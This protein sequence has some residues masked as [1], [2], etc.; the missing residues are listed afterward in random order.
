MEIWL[1]DIDSVNNQMQLSNKGCKHRMCGIAGYLESKYS[2]D[3]VLLKKM[4]DAL[5]HR[6]PDTC[7]VWFDNENRVGLTHRRLSIV[8]LS[9]AGHQPMQS[10]NERFVLTYNGEIYNHLELREELV[11]AGYLAKWRGNSDTETLLACIETWGLELAL[12]RSIGMFSIALWDKLDRTLTLA[13][14]RLGEK[15]LFYGWQNGTLLFGSELKALKAHPSFEAEIDRDVLCLYTRFNYVPSPFC[16]YKDINKLPP[17]SYVVISS[18][19]SC[20]KV[21]SYWSGSNVAIAGVDYPFTGSPDDAVNELEILLSSSIKLQMAADVPLGAFLSGGVD[22]STIVSLMQSQSEKPIKT[23]TMGFT[24][25]LYNEANDAKLIARH[26]G[27]EHTEVYVTPSD[28][29]SVIPK[30]PS[31]YD[32]P[33]SDASQIPTFLVSQ[34]A[35]QHVTV[36]LSG[37]GGDEL[38][39]GYNRYSLTSN[40]WG[41]ISATPIFLRR[42]F[43]N[44][45]TR[46]PPNNWNKLFHI[47]QRFIPFLRNHVNIGEKLHKGGSILS[48]KSVDELYLALVSHWDHSSKLVINGYEPRTIAHGGMLELNDLD[49][50]QRMMV[51]DV[52]TYLP[53]DILCK[54]DRAAMG[55]SLET[56][57]PFLDHRVVEFAWKL[58]QD[59]KLRNGQTKW[60]LRQVLYKYVPKEMIERPKMGFGIPIGDWLRGPLKGWAEELLDESRIRNDGYFNPEPV[61]KKWLEH[62]SGKRNWQY[63]LWNILMFNAWKNEN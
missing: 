37:D 8:D 58:P 57:V 28:A 25:D 29:M 36:S 26:L 39:A 55:V 20:A 45:I 42:L 15:P 33:F 43:T 48:C 61:R 21:K 6:G 23:F 56:R 60:V 32:E 54:V 4:S 19:P 62:L 22:S 38:F 46:I 17:G 16:I 35:R 51:Y 59:Y 27:T 30:L 18:N 63:H 52:L 24:D 47:L 9:P 14:D 34:L 12:Q 13:R 53:D 44:L 40:N 49:E 5:E 11:K 31:L 7:G 1:S 50:I 41:K 10:N 2:N 3:S